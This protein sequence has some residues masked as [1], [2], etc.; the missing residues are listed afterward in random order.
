[1]ENIV[2]YLTLYVFVILIRFF[3]LKKQLKQDFKKRW[4]ET[5][6]GSLEIVYTASGF[7]IALLLNVPKAWIAAVIVIYLLVVVFSAFLE[8]SNEGEFSPISKALLHVMI[9]LVMVVSTVISYLFIIPKVDINGNLTPE[10]DLI[11]SKNYT[12]I[13]PYFDNSLAKHIG[14]SKLTG[15]TFYY[16]YSLNA[17]KPDSLAII[18]VGNVRKNNLIKPIMPS[19][20]VSPDDIQIIT[21]KIRIIESGNF[22]KIGWN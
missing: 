4:L 1:M 14:Y 12:I 20:T 18:A 8:M 5:F 6:H 13:I 3:K 11:V 17:T 16:E 21:E 10:K 9:V 2:Y 15:R 22:E 7:I 19:T